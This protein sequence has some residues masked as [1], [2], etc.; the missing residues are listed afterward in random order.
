MAWEHGEVD[1]SIVDSLAEGQAQEEEYMRGY[2]Q[3]EV[4]AVTE[5]PQPNSWFGW[6]CHLLRM[7]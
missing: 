4:Q 6:I 1:V 3:K 5:S 7:T 2:G